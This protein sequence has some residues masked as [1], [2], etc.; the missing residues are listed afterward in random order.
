MKIYTLSCILVSCVYVQSLFVYDVI[1]WLLLY[2]YSKWRAPCSEG[3]MTME[4]P[5]RQGSI[6]SPSSASPGKKIHMQ[7]LAE[8]LRG[9]AS[10]GGRLGKVRAT[11][12]SLMKGTVFSSIFTLLTTCIGAGTLSLP[13]AFNKVRHEAALILA[14][15]HLFLFVHN[16]PTCI[17]PVV[18]QPALISTARQVMC[19]TADE[20]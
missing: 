13:F 6:N 18:Y 15:L 10:G 19:I 16:A 11:W 1:P 17:Y 4:P 2:T 9:R 14:H 3:F 8:S 5:G 7:S 12:S 20:S